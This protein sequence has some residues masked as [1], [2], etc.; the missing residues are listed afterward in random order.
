VGQNSGDYLGGIDS[1]MTIQKSL[2]TN[3]PE[4]TLC[5]RPFGRGLGGQQRL[6]KRPKNHSGR[7]S[8]TPFLDHLAKIH[9]KISDKIL[10]DS[11]NT[12]GAPWGQNR[13]GKQK[14]RN[15][16]PRWTL[17]PGDLRYSHYQTYEGCLEVAKSLTFQ[18]YEMADA[19]DCPDYIYKYFGRKP[20]R[21]NYVC[22]IC[23][24][25]VLISQLTLAKQSKAVIDTD[26]LDPTRE[27]LHTPDNVA[28]V[29]HECNTTKGERSLEQFE[30][31]MIE[32]LQRKGLEINSPSQL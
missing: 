32:V 23:L 12:R 7:C 22:P 26:H 27:I 5:N 14:F 15:R 30:K 19:P 13:Q 29:H 24:T 10:R 16:Q 20:V 6:C 8:D 1:K 3:S 25:P 4:V 11:F 28:L 18:V 2:F 31:W 9:P 17:K 21:G